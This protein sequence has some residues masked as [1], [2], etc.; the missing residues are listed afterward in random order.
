MPRVAD[1]HSGDVCIPLIFRM[2]PE[3]SVSNRKARRSFEHRAQFFHILQQQRYLRLNTAGSSM[4]N[5]VD[6]VRPSHLFTELKKCVAN[7]SAEY[8]YG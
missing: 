1:R 7:I 8:P 2:P 4:M 6:Q 3:P 5:G